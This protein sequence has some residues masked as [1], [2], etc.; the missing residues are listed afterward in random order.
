[1][2][3]AVTILLLLLWRFAA[4]DGAKFDGTYQL[5]SLANETGS[6][7]TIPALTQ[8]VLT[9]V[10]PSTQRYKV[11]VSMKKGQARGNYLSGMARIRP[12]TGA[13]SIGTIAST[14][15]YTPFLA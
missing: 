11:S 4:G 15:M 13:T 7:V 8:L 14:R 10:D 6:A 12:A 5:Q 3:R 1:M 9:T 2:K